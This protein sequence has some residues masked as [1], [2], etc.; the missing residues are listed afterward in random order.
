MPKGWWPRGVIPLPRSGAAARVP[1]CH[2]AGTAEMSY[3]MSEVERRYPASEVRGGNKRS[4]S[5][6]EIRGGGREEIPHALKPEARGGGREELPHAVAARA[7]EGLEELSH[8][9]GQEGRW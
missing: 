3:P 9:E 8:I 6:S 1:E 4:Y 2:S 7:Q 5:T